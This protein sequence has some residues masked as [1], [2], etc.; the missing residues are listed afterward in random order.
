MEALEDLALVERSYQQ[1]S[2]LRITMMIATTSFGDGGAEVAGDFSFF[3]G[4]EEDKGRET[5]RD[6]EGFSFVGVDEDSLC[7][8]LLV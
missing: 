6:V 7:S 1:D 5:Q 2:I 8:N 3:G 4:G